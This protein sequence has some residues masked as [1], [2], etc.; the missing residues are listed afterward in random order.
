LQLFTLVCFS[1]NLY[2]IFDINNF[3]EYIGAGETSVSESEVT[4]LGISVTV[5]I[6]FNMIAWPNMHE[7]VEG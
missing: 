3:F 4:S 5:M 1:I 2:L 7:F 6:L